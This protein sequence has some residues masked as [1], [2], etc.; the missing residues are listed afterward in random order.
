MYKYILFDFDGTLVNTNDLIIF[1]L[2]AVSKKFLKRSLS[3]KELYSILGKYLDEQMRCLSEEHCKNMVLFYKEVYNKNQDAMTKEFEGVGAMLKQ[4][5]SIGC[6]MAIVSAKGRGGIER[7][8]DLFGYRKYFDVIISAYDIENNKPH[9]EP[10]LK[11]MNSLNAHPEATLLVGDSPYDILCGRN[12]GIKTVLV[13]WTIFP[14]EELMALKPDYVIKTPQEL[15]DI[16][17]GKVQS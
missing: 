14:K 12:A 4:L 7:G 5:K 16:A 6:K 10:A 11:A 9:S 8:L 17:L 2:D 15:V 1:S 13:D 3:T